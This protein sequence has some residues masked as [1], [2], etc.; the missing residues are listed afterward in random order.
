MGLID[1]VIVADARYPVTIRI[2]TTIDRNCR[3]DFECITGKECTAIGSCDVDI[4]LTSRYGLSCCG[5]CE[6][7]NARQKQDYRTLNN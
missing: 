5:V 3:P 7:S 6:K 4:A 1:C 2:G